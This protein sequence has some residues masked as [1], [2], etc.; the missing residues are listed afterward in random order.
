MNLRKSPS[1]V[2]VI[3]VVAFAT[4]AAGCSADDPLSAPLPPTREPLSS[5]PDPGP[6]PLFDG[7]DAA[8]RSRVVDSTVWV[9]GLACGRARDGSGFA[10][11][12]DLVATAAHVIAKT[13]HLTV[14]LTDGRSLPA[15]PV[16][17]DTA[18]DLALLRV[19]HAALAPLPLGDAADGT[20]GVLVGWENDPRPDPTPFR[21]DRPVNV[22]MVE[23][24]GTEIVD[25]PSWLLA[26]EVEAGD[27]GAALVNAEGVVVGIVFA[28]TKR[29]VGVAYAVRATALAEKLKG[30]LSTVAKVADCG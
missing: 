5:P 8:T 7:L 29:H 28:T 21:I 25:R 22:Q 15:I 16:L 20:V 10:V 11:G 27:S 4:F 12:P 30:D 13:D 3:L 1:T 9:S 18:N 17:F 2:L 23:V 24:E 26:A 14:T 19:A 6:P